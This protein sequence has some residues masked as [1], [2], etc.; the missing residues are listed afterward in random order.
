MLKE[1]FDEFR[2]FLQPSQMAGDGGLEVPLAACWCC[3]RDHLLQVRIEHL[4]RV[5][6]RAVAGQGEDLNVFP[7]L[8]QPGLD[9]LAVVN[10]EVVQDPIH[11]T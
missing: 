1:A 5:E 3:R 2:Q 8:L 7:V 9:G 11:R 6:L 4:V 10:L